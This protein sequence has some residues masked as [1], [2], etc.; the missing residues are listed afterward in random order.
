MIQYETID[1]YW[2]IPN[3][4][5][6]WFWFDYSSWEF[7]DK[8]HDDCHSEDGGGLGWDAAI[9]SCVCYLRTIFMLRWGTRW[10]E[11]AH[12]C[13]ATQG[14]VRGLCLNA[15]DLWCFH[16]S[17]CQGM[18]MNRLKNNSRD[19]SWIMLEN[20]CATHGRLK[21]LC[22]CSLTILFFG[23]NN[24]HNLSI[25]QRRCLVYHIPCLCKFQVATAQNLSR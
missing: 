19:I 13:D 23:H 2:I 15:V 25:P 16:I 9:T 3:W 1:I 4:L 17:T 7:R 11:P 21:T 14:V 5:I 24:N 18:R 20:R 22:L 12:T 8:V 6:P 10:L